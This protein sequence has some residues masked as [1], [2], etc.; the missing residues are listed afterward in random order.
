MNQYFSNW[1]KKKKTKKRLEFHISSVS[2][3]TNKDFCILFMIFDS[4]FLMNEFSQKP[5][6]LSLSL[7]WLFFFLMNSAKGLIEENFPKV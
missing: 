5:K 6:S 1:G 3:I 4:Q 7:T 2:C